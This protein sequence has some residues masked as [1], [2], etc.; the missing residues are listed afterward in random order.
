MQIKIDSNEN[1]KKSFK[2]REQQLL[3]DLRSKES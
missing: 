2:E 1:E 3:N